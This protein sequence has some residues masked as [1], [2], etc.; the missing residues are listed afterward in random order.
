[1]GL[2]MGP[3]GLLM[4]PLMGPLTGPLMGQLPGPLAGPLK[5]PL[6][7]PLAGPLMGPLARAIDGPIGAVGWVVDG[8]IAGAIGWAADG[9]IDEAVGWAIDGVVGVVDGA[10]EGATG[11]IA[12]VVGEAVDGAVGP[13]GQAD[14]GVNGGVARHFIQNGDCEEK[15][16]I[17]EE[18]IKNFEHEKQR[19]EKEVAICRETIK[20]LESTR[21]KS[22]VFLLKL[23]ILLRLVKETLVKITYNFADEE[24]V[25]N[26]TKEK[27]GLGVELEL[28]KESKVI[29]EE[30]MAVTNIM[31]VAELKVYEYKESRKKEN[32]KSENSVVSL[33]EENRNINGLLKIALVEMEAAEKS[34][35][36]LNE[37]IEQ[38]RAA[39][40]RLW[41]VA[42]L[43]QELQKTKTALDISNRKLN[44]K[45]E[46]AAAAMAAQAAAEKSLLLADSTVVGLRSR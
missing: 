10:I 29:S 14:D 34:L 44:L 9:A 25:E 43:T 36:R 28:D 4:G 21:E 5:G 17:C 20:R 30:L 23:S 26:W 22:K 3:L 31:K 39:I 12:E 45:E 41:K 6:T 42:I 33:T 11:A 18:R 40:C 27:D 38:K 19:C 24:K 7:G 2:L 13:V 15:L 37:N 16:R 46:L 32:S 8:A 1:M 35:C